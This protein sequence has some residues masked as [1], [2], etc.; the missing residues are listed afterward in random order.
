VVLIILIS[1]ISIASAQGEHSRRAAAELQVI[2]ADVAKLRQLAANEDTTLHQKGLHDR[3]KSGLSSLAILLRL[4]DQEKGRPVSNVRNEVSKAANLLSKA[5]WEA[6]QAQ[7]RQLE[8]GYDLHIPTLD[9]TNSAVTDAIELHQQMCA[10][11][12]DN[13]VSD[14][15]RPAYNLYKQAKQESEITFFARMLVGVRGDRVTGID[16]PLS[17]LQL[18]ALVQLYRAQETPED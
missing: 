5:N 11:C 8:A 1:T 18:L 7:L 14:V 3:I 4:A 2:I 17:D 9:L 15:E 16:N 10:A 13:P 6:L 12:H